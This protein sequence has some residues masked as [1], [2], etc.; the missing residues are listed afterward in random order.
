MDH[1]FVLVVR[2]VGSVLTFFKLTTANETMKNTLIF[3]L[4]ILRNIYI[5]NNFHGASSQNEIY[6]TIHWLA[7]KLELYT[8]IYSV[9]VMQLNQILV[10][11]KLSFLFGI[12]LINVSLL[13]SNLYISQNCTRRKWCAKTTEIDELVT[14][15]A[16][17]WMRWE[18]ENPN[19][20]FSEGRSMNAS[21]VCGTLATQLLPQ[22]RISS[23]KKK[24]YG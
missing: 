16:M 19:Q 9:D 24:K 4:I 5:Y 13:S 21:H 22:H 2:L 18:R 11:R 17:K 8:L 10:Q 23:N 12:D 15:R 3:L 14:K 20:E 7:V 1:K 6:T